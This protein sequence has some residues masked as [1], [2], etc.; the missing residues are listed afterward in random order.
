MSNNKQKPQRRG[1]FVE[2]FGTPGN[3]PASSDPIGITRM[4]VAVDRIGFFD[5]NPRRSPNERYEEI[6]ESI[7]TSGLDNPLP[8]SRRPADPPGH[9]IIYKGGNTRLRAL[10]ELWEETKDSHFFEV[11]CDFYPYVSDTDALISHLRENDLRGNMTFIDRALAVQEARGELE[12]ELGEALSLRKLEAEFRQRGFPI[13]IGMMSKLEYAVRLNEAIPTALGSGM[14]KLQVERLSKLEKVALKV[15]QF[16]CNPDGSEQQFRRAVFLPALVSSDAENWNY[17]TAETLVKDKLLSVM[18][19]NINADVVLMDFKKV[20]DGKELEKPPAVQQAPVA[21]AVTPPLVTPDTA[22]N[23]NARLGATPKT[24]RWEEPA[25]YPVDQHE[26]LGGSNNRDMVDSAHATWQSMDD[27]RIDNALADN[28]QR[29]IIINGNG[30]WLEKLKRLRQR[31]YELAVRLAQDCPIP[32]ASRSV[33]PMDK[34]YGFLLT[35]VFGSEYMPQLLAVVLGDKECSESERM[36][37]RRIH[38]I[39]ANVW[40]FLAAMCGLFP[41]QDEPWVSAPDAI[42]TEFIGDDS[43]IHDQELLLKI[44]P[45]VL[46][47][48]YLRTFWLV[49]PPDHLAWVFEMIRNTVALLEMIL[50]H[51]PQTNDATPW[52]VV[53]G[54]Y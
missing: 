24:G 15:W 6:K 37:A 45:L 27:I 12:A 41:D 44:H 2:H 11:R 34:G 47:S 35:D 28:G 33:I 8:I 3:I 19:G 43:Y 42:K 1:L 52:E 30:Q 49:L 51:R 36:D 14:G 32:K 54:G 26:L 39:A 38:M 48:E 7:R 46:S 4:H 21:T 10:K 31:N 13:S 25:Y 22:V 23:V 40:W 17:D 20:V 29:E 5:K 9:Y 50:E 16:H 53:T 18:P